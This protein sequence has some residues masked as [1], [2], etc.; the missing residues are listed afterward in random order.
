MVAFCNKKHDNSH[1][2]YYLNTC[3]RSRLTEASIWYSS[4]FHTLSNKPLLVEFGVICSLRH[5]PASDAPASFKPQLI[6][7]AAAVFISQPTSLSISEPGQPCLQRPPSLSLHQHCALLHSVVFFKVARS[8]KK[9]GPGSKNDTAWKMQKNK[10]KKDKRGRQRKIA[11]I[12]EHHTLELWLLKYTT[13]WLTSDLHTQTLCHSVGTPGQ[14]LTQAFLPYNGFHI[15]VA[16]FIDISRYFRLLESLQQRQEAR[17][18][19]WWNVSKPLGQ[20][21][22]LNAVFGYCMSPSQTGCNSE[23]RF[24]VKWFWAETLRVL[25]NT[26]IWM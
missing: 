4:I 18:M 16:Y 21:C 6:K 22:T 19:K 23:E 17:E 20:P 11:L 1:R 26:Q 25:Q 9:K 8:T 24:G 7:A 5:V 2:H 10:N 13:H 3:D 12:R 14:I 15:T